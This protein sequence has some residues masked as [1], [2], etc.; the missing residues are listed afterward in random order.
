MRQIEIDFEIHQ[1]IELE[2]N[3]FSESPNGAL[4]RL[5][6]LEEEEVSDVEIISVQKGDAG[7]PWSGKGVTLPHGTRVKMSYRGRQADGQI[8]DGKWVVEGVSSASPS[9]AARQA[10]ITKEG[11][12][13]SLNGWNYW[14]ALVPGSTKWKPINH[15]RKK[16]EN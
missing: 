4:R 11:S 7:L 9:D 1:L 5:L 15:L 12:H 16:I 10:A 3:S 13:P 8:V 14:K 2:R 6:G